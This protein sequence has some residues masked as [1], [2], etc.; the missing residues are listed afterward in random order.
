M[1]RGVGST[2]GDALLNRLPAW[3]GWRTLKRFSS[4]MLHDVT[5][6]TVTFSL[7][8]HVVCSLIT[9]LVSSLKKPQRHPGQVPTVQETQKS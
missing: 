3:L 5:A 6:R 9:G 1:R 8:S 4:P 7:A 2:A